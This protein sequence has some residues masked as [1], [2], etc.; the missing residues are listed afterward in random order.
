[1]VNKEEV[2]KF[3][4]YI[5][6]EYN[7]SLTIENLAEVITKEVTD[8]K[9]IQIG[10]KHVIDENLFV[11][12]GFDERLPGAGRM[13]AMGEIDF[14]IKNLLEDKEIKRI[15]FGEDIKE[16][17]KYVYNLD[18]AIIL[19]STKFFVEVFTKL[20]S[21]IDYEEKYP[22]LDRGYR[23]ISIPEKIL[24]NRIIIINKNAIFWRK[25]K[26]HDEYTNTYEKLNIKIKPVSIG[27]VDITIRSVNK[28]EHINKED[29]IIL[30]IKNIE[31]SLK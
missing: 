22:R 24:Q 28:I 3:N 14:L 13:I 1:M 19:L 31:E 11:Q 12:D 4:K 23:I 5:V 21:R 16:F 17:P 2:K 6:E 8:G 25:Q 18:N 26:F 7:L 20:M 15:K 29:I 30:E 10:I 9:F 27:K